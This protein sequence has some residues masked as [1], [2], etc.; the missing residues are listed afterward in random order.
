MSTCARFRS[1]LV[2]GAVAGAA[3]LLAVPAQAADPRE[4]EASRLF[5]NGKYQEALAVYVDLVVDTSNPQ[6]VCEIGR[7]YHRLGNLVEARRNVKE[8]LTPAKLTAPK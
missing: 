1:F 8:C 5:F 7:C 2:A 4:K 6:Y 3:L